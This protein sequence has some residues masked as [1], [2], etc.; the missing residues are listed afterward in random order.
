MDDLR[1]PGSH[2][3]KASQTRSKRL[4]YPLSLKFRERK[5]GSDTNIHREHLP[6]IEGS[7]KNLA[8]TKKETVRPPTPIPNS[9][10]SVETMFHS[11][12]IARASNSLP[13]SYKKMSLSLD[14]SPLSE[15]RQSFEHFA[16]KYSLSPNSDH[17]SVFCNPRCPD[18]PLMCV[19]SLPNSPMTVRRYNRRSVP[20]NFERTKSSEDEERIFGSV[21]APTMF[22]DFSERKGDSKEEMILRWIQ[23]VESKSPKNSQSWCEGA[24]T[25]CDTT[26]QTLPVI[27][28]N[29]QSC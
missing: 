3:S 21:N 28:E 20:S 19:R 24:Q 10:R 11:V 22:G 26:S 29:L 25:E 6:P 2:T 18:S 17:D 4:S 9:I 13:S 15:K 14:L 23:D 8:C 5:W 27:D 12:S 16:S 1:S 7:D